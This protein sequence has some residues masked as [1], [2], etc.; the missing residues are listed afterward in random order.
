M[1]PSIILENE[2]KKSEFCMKLATSD[3]EEWG[4][5][6][7]DSTELSLSY[8]KKKKKV[9]YT[10][11]YNF[12]SLINLVLINL[13]LFFPL[14]I[15]ISFGH[16]RNTEK[17]KHR[18]PIEKKHIISK[19]WVFLQDCIFKCIPMCLRPIIDKKDWS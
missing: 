7:R 19:K 9:L 10:Y 1:C 13:V 18:W 14:I 16:M 4:E 15:L 12:Q 3:T 2:R 17:L 8:R 5:E 6:K 11:L